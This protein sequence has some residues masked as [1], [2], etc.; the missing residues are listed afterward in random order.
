MRLQFMREKDLSSPS[1]GV[2]SAGH[3]M[4]PNFS[5]GLFGVIRRYKPSFFAT[6]FSTLKIAVELANAVSAS[7]AMA[8]SGLCR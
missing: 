3:V 5:D 4:N 7:Y 8:S 2:V 6:M 1:N